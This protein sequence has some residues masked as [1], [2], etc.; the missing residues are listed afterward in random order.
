MTNPRGASRTIQAGARP[1]AMLLLLVSL[2]SLPADVSRAA[3]DTLSS[4]SRTPDIPRQASSESITA[5]KRLRFI[6]DLYRERDDF[7]AESEIL[8]LL[9]E[10]PDPEL[11]SL[12]ELARAKLYYRAGRLEEAEFMV[13]SLLDRMPVG[14]VAAD[15]RRLL[16]YSKI[17]QGRL[18]EALPLLGS[19]PALAALLEA[20]PYDPSRAASWSTALPGAGF[21][22]LGEPGRAVSALSLN[23][24]LLAGV[25]LSYEQHNVPVALLFLAVESAFYAGGRE[26]VREEAAKLNERWLRERR[27]TWLGRSGEP[28]LMATAFRIRF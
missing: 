8:G 28:A 27:E 13:V 14:T 16:G 7:R 23:L 24:L 20:A 21:W 26:A 3:D 1:G 4:A 17:R 2:C 9:H 19:D 12:A 25:V 15:A 6:E 18:D 11:R 5:V 10:I 22:V